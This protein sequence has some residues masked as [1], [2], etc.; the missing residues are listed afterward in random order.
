MDVTFDKTGK[1]RVLAAEK[2]EQ[3]KELQVQTAAFSNS[4]SRPSEKKGSRNQP[5]NNRPTVSDCL[6]RTLCMSW[7]DPFPNP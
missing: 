5:P 6:Y 1:V 2:Y 4:E 7:G 3:T